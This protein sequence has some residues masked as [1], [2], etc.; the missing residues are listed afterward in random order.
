MFNI[1][2]NIVNLIKVVLSVLNMAL[3]LRVFSFSQASDVYLLAY[4]IVYPFNF[5]PLLLFGQFMQFYNDL[6]TRSTAAAH[7]FYNQSL[8]FAIG[9][10]LVLFA[11][12]YFFLHPLLRMHTFNLDAQRLSSLTQVM[13]IMVFTILF[14]PLAGLL[15][16]FFLAEK[17]F[18][19]LY[20]CQIIMILLPTL[21]LGYMMLA[22]Q[23]NVLLL[24]AAYTLSVILSAV[25][26]ATVI[27]A[28]NIPLKLALP[29]DFT[30][31]V[32]N[33]FTT[34][35]GITINNCFMPVILNN[36]LVNFSSG[37][38]SCFYYSRNALTATDMIVTDYSNKLIYSEI[39]YS[40]AENN[41]ARI[42]QLIRKYLLY[43][44]ACFGAAALL[45]YTLIPLG[46][47]I[48]FLKTNLTM[49]VTLFQTLF[50]CLIPWFILTLTAHPYYCVNL[51]NKNSL[52]VIGANLFFVLV[53]GGLLLVCRKNIYYIAWGLLGAQF[54]YFLICFMFYKKWRKNAA[55]S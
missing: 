25:L 31:F 35:L 5:V 37:A 29:K 13:R 36:F 24:A 20:T 44:P 14:L 7:D 4:S 42:R 19:M 52:S 46:L 32:K 48:V 2:Y 40:M 9:T 49:D 15:E 18:L 53:L 6:K 47:K 16:R 30:T 39:S 21:S 17:N 12:A 41:P 45:L 10:G 23:P 1:K 27:A 8:V 22:H 50:L 55:Q 34:H 11:L 43:I 38:I 51:S 26:G 54:I 33:S 28:K 3:M